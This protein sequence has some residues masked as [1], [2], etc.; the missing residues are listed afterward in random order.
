[1]VIKIITQSGGACEPAYRNLLVQHISLLLENKERILSNLYLSSCNPGVSFGFA[2]TGSKDVRL[3]SLLKLWEAPL[4][5]EGEKA[6]LLSC[7][8]LLSTNRSS[9]YLSESRRMESGTLD[10][11][12][13]TGISCL[14]YL[15]RYL[16]KSLASDVYVDLPRLL[17]E[18]Q[19]PAQ[20][21]YSQR[22]R[23]AYKAFRIGLK[24]TSGLSDEQLKRIKLSYAGGDDFQLDVY[25]RDLYTPQNSPGLINHKAIRYQELTDA[26]LRELEAATGY[27]FEKKIGK[28]ENLLFRKSFRLYENDELFQPENLQAIST[29]FKRY[30]EGMKR[31]HEELV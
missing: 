5:V 3:G 16:E 28:N 11:K 6:Y 15:G 22:L 30:E 21:P 7:G 4:E 25:I 20:Y 12:K 14:E 19:D 23:L 26:L 18:L 29:L 13:Y 27:N 1:M 8:A 17:Q 24:G 2:Y 31:I 9:W 10:F